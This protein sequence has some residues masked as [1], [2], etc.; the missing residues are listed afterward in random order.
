MPVVGGHMG[1]QS[2]IAADVS[3]G[4]ASSLVMG[5]ATEDTQM[6]DAKGGRLG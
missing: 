6:D 1:K 2:D 5:L 3:A 4:K